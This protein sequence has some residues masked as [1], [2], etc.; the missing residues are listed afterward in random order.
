MESL[1]IGPD[2]SLR[3]VSV[4]HAPEGGDHQG[5]AASPTTLTDDPPILQLM[6]ELLVIV[7]EQLPFD[8]LLAARAT[9]ARLRAMALCI[10]RAVLQRKEQLCVPL[11]LPF[12]D[13]LLWLELEGVSPEW[14]PRL[15]CVLGVLPKLQ[16]LF[17]RRVKPQGSSH[18]P[19]SL[20]E[21]ATL[22]IAGA[23]Q[24]GACR[25]LHHLNID[26]RLAEDKV[27]LIARSM[28]PNGGLLFGASHGY[29]SVI[30]EMLRRGAS[31]EVTIEDGA[32][33]LIVACYH[34]G[35]PVTRLLAH[36]ADVGARRH[37]GVSALIMASN[38]GHAKT[39][40][41]LLDAR[42]DVNLAMRDGTTALHTATYK[43]HTEVVA[44][45][46]RAGALV[47]ARCHDGVAALLMAAKSG[48]DELVRMLLKAG[49][50][51]EAALRDGG[52]PLL[53]AAYK[54]H[55]ACVEALL[56]YGASVDAARADG[57]TPLCQASKA[58][59]VRCVELLLEG[60]ANVEA[61]GAVYG[62]TSLLMASKGGHAEIVEM[63]LRFGAD[64]EVAGRAYGTTSLVAAAQHGHALVVS[65]LLRYGADPRKTLID[66]ST[67]LTKAREAG[68]Q[69]VVDLLMEALGEANWYHEE[70]PE[71]HPQL[72]E[73]GEPLTSHAD[74]G[75]RDG[76]TAPPADAGGADGADGTS[77]AD[78]TGE[79]TP[80]QSA[81]SAVTRML[82]PG[83]IGSLTPARGH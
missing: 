54:G 37:D 32:N 73:L 77:G 30:D 42:A 4:P 75:D 39:V 53:A 2:S 47:Q 17:I 28:H 29:E 67:A 19:L 40:E 21:T 70:L 3:V 71:E 60:G 74:D 58:G 69:E 44:A 78:D 38:R 72:D 27:L 10:T 36:G 55:D 7:L 14:L 13:A 9:C 50:D 46:I 57:L 1:G 41:A 15:G 26:E 61:A 64:T 81:T 22:A 18:L 66:G 25:S 31:S 23:L 65:L 80:R 63:L 35:A 43:G 8:T 68:H 16:R 34:G 49:A 11:L 76:A 62:T 48:R 83:A 5:A 6:P 12:G 59:H 82:S 20:G 52:T 51:V 79:Q 33:A 24:A 45:L 56:Q